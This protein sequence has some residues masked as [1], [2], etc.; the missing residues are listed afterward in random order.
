MK[1]AQLGLAFAL[2]F[3]AAAVR[4]ETADFVLVRKSAAKLYLIR[5]GQA[6][7][8]FHVALGPNPTGTKQH[9]GDGRTPEGR[10]ILD[11]RNVHSAYYKSLHVSY[12][13]AHDREQARRARL[14]AGGDIMIHG[15]PNGWE[16][17]AAVTQLKNWTLGCIALTNEEMDVVWSSVP[18]GTPIQIDP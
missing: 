12:P 15:Q 13:N 18:L 2:A 14:A 10:Y 4:A 1:P 8:E 9:Q 7:A 16:K 3:A 11:A 6:F 17:Y 5:H